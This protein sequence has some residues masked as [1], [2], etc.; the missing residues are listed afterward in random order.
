[1]LG[2]L[3]WTARCP[4]RRWLD[5]G[6]LLTHSVYRI[7]SLRPA[8]I[9][10]RRFVSQHLGGSSI[11][12]SYSALWIARVIF[13]F[14]VPHSLR[15]TPVLHSKYQRPTNER[16]R[17]HNMFNTAY[18]P[19]DMS[20]CTLFKN[21]RRCSF[22]LNGGFSTWLLVPEAWAGDI[23]RDYRRDCFYRQRR[24]GVNR[25]YCLQSGL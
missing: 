25:T 22:C 1:V 15:M 10:M 19:E 21:A 12:P 14:V 4:R 18:H 13:R 5:P 16:Y 2:G 11:K 9:S 17:L 8:I 20:I 7:A 24:D 6:S 23:H 3:K